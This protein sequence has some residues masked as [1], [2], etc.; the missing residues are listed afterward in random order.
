MS[1]RKVPYGFIEKAVQNGCEYL[2][3]GFGSVH[4]V[5]EYRSGTEV[6]WK[7]KYLEISKSADEWDEYL[8][9]V[10]E[11]VLEN[12]HFLQKLAVD[13]VKLFFC[14][15]DKICQNGETL[16]ILILEGCNIEG[17]YEHCILK[18]CEICENGEI[19][20]RT[21]LIQEL[22]TKCHQLTELNICKGV[23]D[24]PILE[25]NILLDQHIYL[26]FS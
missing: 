24:S 9:E 11:G 1:E 6:P 25:D 20:H 5:P 19:D 26:C 14:D 8:V 15:I 21:E 17:L 7:L 13:Y 18:S 23:G 10:P 16:R 12:C 22:F 3:L 4:G 2:N